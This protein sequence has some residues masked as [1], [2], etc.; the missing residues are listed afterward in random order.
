M[1]N[2]VSVAVKT[3]LAYF[4]GGGNPAGD[5]PGSGHVASSQIS[6]V[7]GEGIALF[8]CPHESFLPF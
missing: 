8:S 2:G 7:T 4:T 1:V 5:S 3:P 6:K